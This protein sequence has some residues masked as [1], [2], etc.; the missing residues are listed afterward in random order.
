MWHN[1]ETWLN[2]YLSGMKILD[3]ILIL[4]IQQDVETRLNGY[5]SGI[6]I[7]DHILILFIQ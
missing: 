7:L 6:K 3:H 1:V 4:F 5:L 2:G